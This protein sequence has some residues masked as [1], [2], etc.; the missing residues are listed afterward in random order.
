MDRET[1]LMADHLPL[2]EIL[3]TE[4]DGI[5]PPGN[6]TREEGDDTPELPPVLIEEDRGYSLV[7]NHRT[8]WHL[9]TSGRTIVK[10]LVVRSTVHVR[11]AHALISN[12]SEE[13]MLFE[14]IL[15][16]EI[17]ANR[18]RL[19]D[20]LG[21]SRARITQ[22]LNLL[23]LPREIIQK[24][25]ITDDI[26]EFQLR[27]LLKVLDDDQRLQAGFKRLLEKKLSG[28]QMALSQGRNKRNRLNLLTP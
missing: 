2:E 1:E 10:C 4:I 26:S 14:A 18:S 21:Y 23:K 19:A 6:W 11:P 12:C 25:L 5:E 17:V 22:L 7:G 20:M 24:V 13:A 9:K 15:R 27:Q 16:R 8:V 28:R 3:I